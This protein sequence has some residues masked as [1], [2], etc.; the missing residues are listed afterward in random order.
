MCGIA[1][2]F[3]RS[4][5]AAE[6]LVL[7]K[8]EAALRHRGPDSSGRYMEGSIGLLNTRLAIIDVAGGD[9]PLYGTKG[10][11]LVANGEVYNAPLLRDAMPG[12]PFATQ[13]DCE[14]AAHLYEHRG[15]GYAEH[16]RGMYALAI[17]DPAKGR[18]IL[19][20][21]QFG[22]KPLYYVQTGSYF[23]FASEPQALIAAGWRIPCSIPNTV[24][25]F[26]S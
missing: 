16:L 24:T 4:G 20:R 9:Q 3:M 6:A 17:Y 22:I 13:S 10:A 1:G 5:E 23:A 8:L 11:V 7:D 2:I 26:W 25:S 14:P 15:V 21:D 12:E 19:S 18:L